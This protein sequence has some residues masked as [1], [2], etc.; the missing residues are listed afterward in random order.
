MRKQTSNSVPESRNKVIF[1]DV[2]L[3]TFL[4]FAAI[5]QKKKLQPS[6]GYA[7]RNLIERP[8]AELDSAQ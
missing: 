2:L 5:M 4:E 8:R 7:R 3:A 1:A 6:R